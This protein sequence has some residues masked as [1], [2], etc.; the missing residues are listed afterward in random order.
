VEDPEPPAGGGSP[1]LSITVEC[2]SG[3]YVRSLADDLGAALGG[4][5]HLRNLRRLSVGPF[6]LSEA[7][8]LEDVGLDRVLTPAMALRGMASVEVS[9]GVARAVGHGQVLDR[10][11]LE[12]R[13]DGPWA[14]IGAG[15]G[16]ELLAVYEA[17]G[18][19]MKPAVVM[20]PRFVPPGGDRGA[21]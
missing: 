7:C 13:G 21:E 10:R 14:L 9:D 4:G 5:G 11:L 12:L 6:S 3:T 20:Q 19:R 1:V 8:S 18:D 15:G 2:S 16:G 17:H